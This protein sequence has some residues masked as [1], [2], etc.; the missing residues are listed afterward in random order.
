MG[1]AA[2]LFDFYGTLAHADFRPRPIEDVARDHGY[3]LPTDMLDRWGEHPED[4]LD[5]F[6]HSA[7]RDA[8]IAYRRSHRRDALLACG[9]GADDVE[10]LLD[11]VHAQG[12][13]FTLQPY[14]ATLEVLAE[15]RNRGVRIAICSNWDWDLN[16]AIA[17]AGLTGQAE[18]EITS[19]QVGC[20]KPHEEIYK[21]TLEALGVDASDAL[22]VGD[23][24]D[25]DVEGPI[26]AGMTA[27]HIVRGDHDVELRALPPGAHRITSLRGVLD[28]V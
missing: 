24:W 18:V 14:P 23:T 2:V 26:A 6:E 13:L 7:S 4:R 25:C 20:R 15:L 27:V 11:D 12:E 5:H 9:V 10:A 21:V 22:F 28:L 1:Y 16:R 8:Y 17:S 3:A 19:A